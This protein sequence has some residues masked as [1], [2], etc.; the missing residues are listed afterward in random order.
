MKVKENGI[1]ILPALIAILVFTIGC[2]VASKL[3]N[4][5]T[6]V[7]DVA[8]HFANNGYEGN[9]KEEPLAIAIAGM[10]QAG[11]LK[12]KGFDIKIVKWQMN[13]IDEVMRKLNHTYSL[14]GKKEA[15][16][17]GKGYFSVE[18]V[19]GDSS[20]IGRIFERM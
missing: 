12:G 4:Q 16:L 6:N 11:E 1:R 2:S 7:S 20:E 10:E 14:M 15:R 13:G 9:F 19:E 18:V 17:F 5:N 8:Q 3:N